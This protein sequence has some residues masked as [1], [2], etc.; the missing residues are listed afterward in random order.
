MCLPVKSHNIREVDELKILNFAS[1]SFLFLFVSKINNYANNLLG[2]YLM[3]CFVV[4]FH[5]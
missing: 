5:L 1:F 4:S 2:T 3:T